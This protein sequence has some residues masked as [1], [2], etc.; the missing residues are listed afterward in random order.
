MDSFSRK[1]ISRRQFLTY[2]GLA[3]GTAALAPLA[4]TGCG[5]SPASSSPKTLTV[6]SYGGA[7]EEFM[8][9]EVIPDFEKQNNCTIQLAVGLAKDWMAQLR[10]AGVENPPYDIAMFN[11]IFAA[12]LRREGYFIDIPAD[13]V[14]NLKETYDIAR[15]PGDNGVLAMMQPIGLAYRKDKVPNPPKSWKDLW[16]PEYKGQIGLYTITN[17]AGLMFFLLTA[18]VWGK[19]ED[20]YDVAFQKIKEL[21]PFKQT[22]FSGDMEKLLTQGEISI[23]VQD[24]AAVA[25]LKKQGINLE[26]VTPTEGLFMF[27]QDHNVTKGSQNKELA[28][29]YINYQLSKPVQEKWIT[30][31]FIS[32]ANKNAAIPSDLQKDIP[33]SGDRMKE[34]LKWNWDKAN[35]NK[36]AITERWNKEI[37]G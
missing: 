32:P 12:Q 16:N 11:E 15:N 25:R 17:S 37:S 31:Y 19:G 4:M 33:I 13:K 9:K 35:D 14:P 8:R 34:I 27:E 6:T 36:E 23:G 26:Y 7:W 5:Q 10:A 30:G 29:A 2:A 24:L 18:K 28:Y 3:V 1:T 21:K 22:D 20:D